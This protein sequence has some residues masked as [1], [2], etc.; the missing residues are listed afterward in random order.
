MRNIGQLVGTC[1]AYCLLAGATTNAADITASDGT[2]YRKV[3][4][5]ST[6][7][8]GIAVTYQPEGG[9]IGMAKLKFRNLPENLQREYGYNEQK[10]SA[11][12][13]EQVRA[14]AAIQAKMLAA[15][16]DA[17]DRLAQR[18]AREDAQWQADQAAANAKRM[19]QQLPRGGGGN[20]VFREGGGGGTMAG[21]A[22]TPTPM[23]TTEGTSNRR[24][25]PQQGQTGS[26]SGIRPQ[27]VVVLQ[28]PPI[29]KPA[30][31]QV[32]I[33][34]PNHHPTPAPLPPDVI[35]Q[36]EQQAAER[37][38]S[39]GGNSTASMLEA[40]KNAGASTQQLQQAAAQMGA[41]PQ[42]AAAPAR[43]K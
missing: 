26:Q 32:Q 33:P 41:D 34:A 1:L 23:P 9:G 36:I 29:S 6:E 20:A 2:V 12:E 40:L 25:T 42:N 10:A 11:F 3:T 35:N 31:V 27:T 30:L 17:A 24:Q 19:A 5:T 28:P 43:Q 8:D 21:P 38:A 7:P 14:Q 37:A 4:V 22:V 18:L 15:E 39:T 16:R 13:A